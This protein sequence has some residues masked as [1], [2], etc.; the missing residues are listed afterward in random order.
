M[1]LAARGNGKSFYESRKW[2]ELLNYKYGCAIQNVI[3]NDPATIVFWS[4]GTKTVVKCDDYEIFDP[5]KGLAMAVAKKFLGTGQTHGNYY[6]VFKKWIPKDDVEYEPI[7]FDEGLKILSDAV[8]K[9]NEKFKTPTEED[10][11]D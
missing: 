4:D 6:E 10:R 11:K 5:E 7:D 2:K 3:F 8:N 1:I 9:L